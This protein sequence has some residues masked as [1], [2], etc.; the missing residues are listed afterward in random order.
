[1]TLHE[2]LSFL[3]Q[4]QPLPADESLNEEI[5]NKYNEVRVFFEENLY[6]DCIPLFLNSFGEGDGFG[7][8]PL[9]ED[10]M[11][12]YLPEVVIPAL[13]ESLSKGKR[14]VKYWCAQIAGSFPDKRL[15]SPLGLLLLEDSDRDIRYMSVVALEQIPCKETRFILNERA[16]CKIRDA[17]F[18]SVLI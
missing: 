18:G 1:M 16:F 2:A 10:T 12:K 9:I 3:K 14:S 13:V 7:V 5:I 8:Y 15:I 6:P 4:H 11:I 17:K